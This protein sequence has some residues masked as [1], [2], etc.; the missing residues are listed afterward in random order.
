MDVDFLKKKI[1]ITWEGFLEDI[2]HKLR[3]MR[4]GVKKRFFGVWSFVLVCY[5][6]QCIAM[7]WIATATA[8]YG[9]MILREQL[10]NLLMTH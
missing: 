8:S 4:E 6:L 7:G 10:V 1:C 3:C 9:D 5:T 2:H